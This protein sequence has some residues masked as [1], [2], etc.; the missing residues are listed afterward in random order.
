MVKGITYSSLRWI[1]DTLWHLESAQSCH[2]CTL[3][4]T[5]CKK[6]SPVTRSRINLPVSGQP[7]TC[8]FLPSHSAW[9]RTISRG[10][11]IKRYHVKHDMKQQTWYLP[12]FSLVS[13]VNLTPSWSY[14]P[15]TSPAIRNILRLS[16]NILCPW[17]HYISPGCSHVVRHAMRPW[18]QA[19]QVCHRAFFESVNKHTLYHA[20]PHK[21]KL[22]LKKRIHQN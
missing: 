3:A 7:Q 9:M 13:K 11:A 12:T 2:H 14:S 4:L 16:V 6:V 21:T 18:H 5:Y 20:D 10:T 19:V 8:N 17:G 1:S 22:S 15:Q